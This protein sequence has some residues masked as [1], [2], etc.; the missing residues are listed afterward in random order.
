MEKINA[1]LNIKILYIIIFAPVGVLTTL[2]GQYLN[3]IGFNGTQIGT[4]TSIAT[5]CGI[6]SQAFWGKRYTN[7][8]DG[9]KVIGFI[10]I[11]GAILAIIISFVKGYYLFAVLYGLL[12]FFASCVTGLCDTM[13]LELNL[14][15]GNIRLWGA[16]GFGLVVFLGG[17]I[18]EMLSLRSIFYIYATAFV[19]SALILTT[20]R[21]SKDNMFN[22]R[23]HVST[24]SSASKSNTSKSKRLG[25]SQLLKDH[26][27]VQLII[28][29]LFI[30]GTDMANNTY[31]SF[32]Y[33]NGG[34]SLSGFGTIFFLMIIAEA[35][36]M[37]IAPRITQKLG[38]SRVLIITMIISVLRF[39]LFAAG[40]SYIILIILFPLHGFIVGVIIV[41]Y[42]NYL[43]ETVCPK[44]LGLAVA[45]FYAFG[46]N[47]GGIICNLI[48]GIAMDYLGIKGA[49]GV[50]CILNLI[51]LVLFLVFGLH[52][53]EEKEPL[54]SN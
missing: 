47:G 9:R 14:E 46:S 30:Y 3:S 11:I 40:P 33:K 22:S 1:N 51:S 29:A 15:Y 39:A 36:F 16:V 34:G 28:C 20:I 49:Y 23:N 8:R 54:S 4:I 43:K 12:F 6:I 53:T 31:F 7:S 10:C 18:G 26:R 17:K 24:K 37:G 45:A 27:A 38:R 19:I 50:F 5:A 48:G 21:N 41:E 44:L 52:K 32:L 35:P 2:I 25:Y 13:V 42:M